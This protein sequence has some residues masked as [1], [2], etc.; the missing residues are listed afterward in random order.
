MTL[1]ST[2][3]VVANVACL[4][5]LLWLYGGDLVDGLRARNAEVSAFM[6]P[7]RVIWPAVVLVA[8]VGVLGVVLWGLVRVREQPEK[9][10]GYRLLPILL[11]CALFIDL[12]LLESQVPLSPEDVAIM[13]VGQ[14]EQRAQ[15]LVQGVTVPSDPAVLRS[16][17]EEMGQ[18]PYLVRGTRAPAWSLQVRENCEGPIAQAPGLE[19]GTFIYCVAPDRKVAWVSLVGLPAGE[20]FG[21]PAVLSRDGEPYVGIVEPGLSDEPEPFQRPSEPSEPSGTPETG[22]AGGVAPAPNP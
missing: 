18:P 4:V 21:R 20:R 6:T 8:L 15:A 12:A 5:V 19:V 10:K 11:V 2:K 22:D 17:L 16:V 14:F 7:P 1:P 3:T 9:F 13:A